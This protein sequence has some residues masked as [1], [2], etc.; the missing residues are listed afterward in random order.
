ML[1]AAPGERPDDAKGAAIP[2]DL[3]EEEPTH[4]GDDSREQQRHRRLTIVRP[5]ARAA[6]SVLR[7][8]GGEQPI[9]LRAKRSRAAPKRCESATAPTRRRTQYAAVWSEV[10]A[11]S[12]IP[13]APPAQRRRGRREQ[14]SRLLRKSP[15]R[16]GYRR[17]A[18]SRERTPSVCRRPWCPPPTAARRALSGAAKRRVVEPYSSCSSVRQRKRV[19]VASRRRR[20][21][22]PQPAPVSPRAA[23]GRSGALVDPQGRAESPAPCGPVRARS[24]PSS[25]PGD[26]PRPRPARFLVRQRASGTRRSPPCPPAARA[27]R[28]SFSP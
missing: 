8:R 20:R 27:G 10:A 11:S 25:A 7:F 15:K 12:P 14:G 28:R 24:R 22:R 3:R 13:S 2:R 1:L 6:A 4:G 23:R 18:L 5:G 19:Q 9:D 26:I 17:S 21:R 16:N